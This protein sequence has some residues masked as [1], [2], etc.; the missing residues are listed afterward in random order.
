M[1]PSTRYTVSQPSLCACCWDGDCCDARA[2][3]RQLHV[4]CGVWDGRIC[5]GYVCLLVC[6]FGGCSGSSGIKWSGSSACVPFG[7]LFNVCPRR[8]GGK[9]CCDWA[10]GK[11]HVKN[12]GG[13]VIP[14]CVFCTRPN[15]SKARVLHTCCG[16]RGLLGA[17]W[18]T[19][20]LPRLVGH[21]GTSQIISSTGWQA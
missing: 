21:N 3:H 20:Q 19:E 18:A 15:K 10:G 1:I 7:Q 2:T 11:R 13:T 6:A 8:A 12:D 4:L 9:R 14:G 17:M 16:E 5:A